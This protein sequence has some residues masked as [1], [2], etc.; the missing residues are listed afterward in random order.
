MI[1][2]LGSYRYWPELEYFI[3]GKIRC[4]NTEPMINF[5]VEYLML[6]CFDTFFTINCY[7]CYLCMLITL[8][9]IWLGFDIYFEYIVSEYI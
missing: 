3:V 6:L 4:T 1:Y 7:L 8:N 2:R 9:A 5:C